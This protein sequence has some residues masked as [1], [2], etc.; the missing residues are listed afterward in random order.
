MPILAIGY[1]AAG[2][3]AE[4]ADRTLIYLTLRPLPGA[5]I[6]AA[7]FAAATLI[8]IVATWLALIASFVLL[9]LSDAPA[10]QLPALLIAGALGSA[11][12][13]AIFMLL[14]LLLRRALLIGA[15]YVLIWEGAFAGLSTSAADL[16][17]RFYTFGVYAGTLR[18]N[19]LV[20]LDTFPAALGSLIFLVALTIAAVWFTGDRLRRIELP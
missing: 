19:D 15:I 8:T 14:G 4:R 10:G 1:G 5:G 2:I 20:A 13:C 17:V 16:S 11:A 12:Y 7:K 18:R 6:A 3:G 9:G